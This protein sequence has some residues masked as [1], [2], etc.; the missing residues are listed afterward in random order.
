VAWT[1]T[2][3]PEAFLALAGPL[4]RA[5][6][7]AHSVLLTTTE[8]LRARAAVGA[9]PDVPLFGVWR[10]PGGAIAGAFVERAGLPILPTALPDAAIGPLVASLAAHGRTPSAVNG[11]AD[12]AAAFAA[13]WTAHTGVR[14]H[15]HRR[16]C[17]HRLDALAPPDPPPAGAG[18]IATEAD[19]DLLVRWWYAFT[20][21]LDDFAVGVEQAVAGRIADGGVLVWRVDGE[22]VSIAG[23]TRAVAGMARVAPVYT[24]P[25]HRGR[26]Y[27]AAATAAVTRRLLDAG[28][29]EV[30]LFTDLANPTSNRLYR[31]LGYRPVEEVVTLVFAA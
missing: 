25:E 16:M 22:P 21:E 7:A 8:A 15:V 23:A 31:R 1:T 14:A 17:L 5:A 12:V 24:P 13:A 2:H 4:L 26:G 11:R 10:S 18:A 19:H 9:G 30:L 20:E 28:T 29:R 3:D 27:A 6:P